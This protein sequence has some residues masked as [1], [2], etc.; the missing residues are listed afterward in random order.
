MRRL[1]FP[2]ISA[3]LPEQCFDAEYG[4]PRH[5]RSA[6]P[7]RLV[8]TIK[9]IHAIVSIRLWVFQMR[10]KRI[11][12]MVRMS[13]EIRNQIGRT[14]TFECIHID[15]FLAYQLEE[16]AATEIKHRLP[17]VQ[18]YE[19]LR[20]AGIRR[21]DC[22]ST[23]AMIKSLYVQTPSTWHPSA[24]KNECQNLQIDINC[25]GIFDGGLRW[26]LDAI[27]WLTARNQT[28]GNRTSKG[29]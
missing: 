10:E 12:A 14:L 29:S 21:H 9:K 7:V 18:L 25:G 24:P 22:A 3:L 28:C 23:R 13:R 8:R 15:C 6:A 20:H 26:Q 19:R 1:R 4:E 5:T 11:Y 16:H 27:G 2:H 17:I